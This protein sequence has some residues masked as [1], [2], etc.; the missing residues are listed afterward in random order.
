MSQNMDTA[1]TETTRPSQY[2]KC[3]SEHLRVSC[4]GVSML[5]WTMIWSTNANLATEFSLSEFI[6]PSET[7]MLVTIQLFSRQ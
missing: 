2:R 4:H 6:D 7:E 3:L 1:P 5:F